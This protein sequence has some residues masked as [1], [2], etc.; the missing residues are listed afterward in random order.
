MLHSPSTHSGLPV[1]KALSA[2][3]QPF[4]SPLLRHARF[5]HPTIA[6]S[7]SRIGFILPVSQLDKIAASCPRR[8]PHPPSCFPLLAA[9]FILLTGASSSTSGPWRRHVRHR[10]DPTR[11][12][13]V[14]ESRRASYPEHLAAPRAPTPVLTSAPASSLSSSSSRSTYI[15]SVTRICLVY[16]IFKGSSL[17]S[18][19]RQQKEEDR[20]F[21]H[22]AYQLPLS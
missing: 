2:A 5:H 3:S 6:F 19:P 22:R 20:R 1:L 16:L 9:K 14:F 8:P 7:T 21:K 13:S 10:R 12:S 11:Q 18:R 17:S 4:S 15:Q